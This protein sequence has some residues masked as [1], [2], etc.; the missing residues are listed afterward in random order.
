MFLQSVPT[1]NARGGLGRL[2]AWHLPGGPVGPASRW[3]AKSNVEIGQTIYL[4]N[5][6]RVMREGREGSEGQSL[7]KW[8]RG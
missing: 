5:G 1:V 2:A 8:K 4:A 7:K 3:A 6:G